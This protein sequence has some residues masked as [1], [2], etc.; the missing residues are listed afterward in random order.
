MINV[1]IKTES[2]YTVDRQRIRSAVEKVL[3]EKG[4]KGKIEVSVNIVGDRLMKELNKKYRNLDETTDVLSFPLG[5]D[6]NDKPFV[7]PPDNILRL[8]DIIIS[9]PQAREDASVEN[10]LVDDKIDELVAHSMLHLLGQ[11]HE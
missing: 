10:K 4:V 6:A 8:G 1:L 11:H 9:Y 2:H 3:G 5:G 7:D